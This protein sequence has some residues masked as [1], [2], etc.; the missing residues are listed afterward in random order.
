MVA[1]SR[2][3]LVAL[4]LTLATG[5]SAA[6]F[7]DLTCAPVGGPAGSANGT[8]TCK[9]AAGGLVTSGSVSVDQ[10]KCPDGYLLVEAN[11]PGAILKAVIT[12]QTGG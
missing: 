6:Q 5:V 10:C 9:D 3:A 4:G 2:I 8:L 12:S 7:R 11:A 1:I